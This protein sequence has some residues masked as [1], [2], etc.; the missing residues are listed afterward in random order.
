MYFGNASVTCLSRV[1]AFR[2]TNCMTWGAGQP[3][4][5]WACNR[6]TPDIQR[7]ET[8]GSEAVGRTASKGCHE[9]CNS[10][11]RDVGR[12]EE[13]AAPRRP[14]FDERAQCNGIGTVGVRSP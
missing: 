4:F 3:Q 6:P 12:K 14:V 1:P 5:V 9:R 2:Q 11:R 8:K 13:Q 7:Y 10:Q